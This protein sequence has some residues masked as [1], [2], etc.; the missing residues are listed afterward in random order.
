MY[1]T[2]LLFSVLTASGAVPPLA[3]VE[4]LQSVFRSDAVRVPVELGV[5]S[6]CPDALLCEPIFDAVLQKV[7]EK[8]DLEL[9]YVAKINS[10]D[11]DFGVTCLHGP[12]EC[13]GNVQQLCAAKYSTR[14]WDFVRCQNARGRYQV[15]LPEVALECAETVGIDWEGSGVGECAGSD[16]SGKGEEGVELLR[17]STLRGKALGIEK[18]CTVLIN[19]KKVCI[20]DGTWKEC[21]GGH[22]VDDF[23]RQINS[24]YERLNG[25]FG[26]SY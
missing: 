16:G 2:V 12:G 5:M 13:A 8:V 9:V 6:R 15:G 17:A 7:G 20:H 14:W 19:H 23:V 3:H 21:E 18:S 24:E 10:T 1:R 26:G 11:S 4:S 22:G 25:E